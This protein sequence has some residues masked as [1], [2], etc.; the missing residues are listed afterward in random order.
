MISG[1]TDGILAFEGEL[2]RLLGLTAAAALI[3]PKQ[4][5]P[6]DIFR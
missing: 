6:T 2:T 1:L 4:D 3:R 5:A